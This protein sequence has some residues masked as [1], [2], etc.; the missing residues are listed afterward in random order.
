M[1]SAITCAGPGPIDFLEAG[2]DEYRIDLIDEGI[3][4]LT[5]EVVHES[6]PYTDTIAIVVL[7][8][9]EIDA[10]LQQKWAN[11]KTQLAAKNIEGAVQFFDDSKKSLYEEVFTV[12]SNRLP[13]IASD[14]QDISMIEIA[15]RTAKYRIR[16]TETHNTG[17][18]S[19]TYYIYFIMDEDGL[20]KLY[21]F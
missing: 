15:D 19:I 8:A 16:R 9:V 7:D 3:Y 14:M 10:L 18:Y 17:T 11:I 12:L 21:R 6:I 1:D 20:W 5:A 13:Q 2:H 4:Y